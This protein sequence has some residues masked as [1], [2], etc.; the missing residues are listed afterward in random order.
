M[1]LQNRTVALYGRFSPG[2]RD[3]LALKIEAAGGRVVRDLTRR[4]DL[5]VI[6]ARADSLIESGALPARLQAARNHRR[7]IFGE[8]AFQAVISAEPSPLD[9]TLP[10]AAALHQSGADAE[11]AGLL[12]AFDLILISDDKCR[13]ADMTVLRTASELRAAGCGAVRLVRIIREASETSPRGRHRVIM[14]ASGAP[15]LEWENGRTT[16]EG[17]GF[18][19]LS[20]E[21]SSLEDVFELA[22]Q[23]E[24]NGDL[25]QAAQLFDTCA[26]ADR[27]DALALYN[28]G[29][30]R[31][32]QSR[33]EEAALAY[34]RALARDPELSEARYN[35]ALAHEARGRI[36]AAEDELHA[37][38]RLDP[39]HPDALFN[40][41]QLTMNAAR[42]EDAA[43][44][45]QRFLET[46][47]ER[48][49]EVKAKK[50]IAYCRLSR[51]AP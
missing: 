49:W 19:P 13:F 9:A 3:A 1:E 43:L 5:L 45:Y 15:A 24:V 37:L 32:R 23:A 36:E 11:D 12:A 31:L 6:G 21:S 39:G 10:L 7:S 33:A 14:T 18:L 51:E 41:A 30:I 47:P 27:K 40:L 26:R 50:A 22:I 44:L 25:D 20:V 8:R 48:D 46:G 34:Q 29:N 17:Q 28:F 16:L 4:A 35:L 2:V 38:L 42:L